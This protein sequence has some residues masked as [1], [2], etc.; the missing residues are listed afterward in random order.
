MNLLYFIKDFSYGNV[1]FKIERMEAIT[2]DDI[3]ILGTLH[4]K[5]RDYCERWCNSCEECK[6]FSV[7]NDSEC[8]LKDTLVERSDL[9]KDSLTCTTYY[10]I[11]NGD[12]LKQSKGRNIENK[13]T[14]ADHNASL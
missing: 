9:T 8:R 1:P 3:K 5:S 2:I 14:E 13:G 6:S 4:N 7:C 11:Q 10:R 12:M